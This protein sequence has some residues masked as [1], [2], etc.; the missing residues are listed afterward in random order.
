MV[1]RHTR[2]K[3]G[4]YTCRRR[5]KKC[6]EA[7]PLCKS[8]KANGLECTWPDNVVALHR[9]PTIT[10]HA[11]SGDDRSGDDRSPVRNR[12]PAPEAELRLYSAQATRHRVGKPEKKSKNYFL[13]RIAMQQD[14]VADEE[15]EVDLLDVLGVLDAELMEVLQLETPLI[16]PARDMIKNRI[17]HQMDIS[18]E[19]FRKT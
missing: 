6:D 14:C 2:S 15:R 12:T 9:Q 8:C 11:V 4:C 7:Y 13:Q 17:A 1:P 5:K 19:N 3:N 16:P 10:S 18:G